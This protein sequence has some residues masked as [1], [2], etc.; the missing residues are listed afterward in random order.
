[1]AEP[2]SYHKVGADD[3]RYGRRICLLTMLVFVTGAMSR[4]V[5]KIAP[6]V[7]CQRLNQS[8]RHDQG[9]IPVVESII[10]GS[11]RASC[12]PKVRRDI[13]RTQR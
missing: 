3:F 4:I 9:W 2:S 5:N 10:C 12:L 6:E 1:M 8:Q 11:K 7:K 13:R